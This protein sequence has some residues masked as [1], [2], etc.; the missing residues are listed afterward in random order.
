MKFIR[1]IILCALALQPI[2][3][4]AQSWQAHSALS[5]GTWH[6]IEVRETGVY[7]LGVNELAS[8]EG[9][10]FSQ[11]GLFGGNARQMDLD[12]T[13]PET[14]DLQP[15]AYRAVD[16]NNNGRLDAGDYL[17][18][19][20][21]GVTT[22]RYDPE[23]G[24]YLHQRHAYSNANYLFLR[25][26]CPSSQQ[27]PQADEQEANEAA[28]TEFTL[29]AVHE[30]ET[31]NT[32]NT[33]Q[34]W[35]GEKFLNGMSHDLSLPLPMAVSGSA[36]SLRVALAV[37]EGSGCF[38][39]SSGSQS[40]DFSL[41]YR[42]KH[43]VFPTT[44]SLSNSAQ[45]TFTLTYA[46][47]GTAAA[48]LDYIELSA[49]VP[50][51]FSQQTLLLHTNRTLGSGH[52]AQHRLTFS[53]EKPTVW[54]VTN[55]LSAIEM[56]TQSSGSTLQFTNPVDCR[57][58]YVVFAASQALTPV[59][60]TALS[61][62][63]L[64]GHAVPDMV[65]VSH[66]QFLGQAQRLGML[67]E[68]MEGLSV[69]VVTQDQVFNEFSSG[70]PDPVAVREMLRCLR[71]RDG[72]E[73]RLRYLLLFGKGTY[74]NRDILQLHLPT[75]ITYQS[76]RGFTDDCN[77]SVTD[78]VFG[79][80]DYQESGV[81]GRH[82]DLGIGRLPAKR[83][84][85]A[86]LMVDKIERYMNRADLEMS[87]VRGD[88]R[89]SVCLL[90]DDAD[91]SQEGDIDFVQSSEY[92]ANKIQEQAP[93]INL[94]KIYADAYLQQSGTIGSYYPDVNNALKQRMDY[95]CMLL[96]YI[97]HGS[98]Q[99]IGTERYIQFSDIDGY[100]NFDRLP[101]FVTSTCSYGK[102][103][104]LDDLCGSE[105]F[106]LARAAG[107]G[108]IAAARPI[109]HVKAFNTCLSAGCLDP[110]NRV[111]DA[112]RL[113]K[114]S[115]SQAQNNSIALM[116]DPALRLAFPEHRVVVTHINGNEVSDSRMD[117]ALVLSRVT[118]EGEIQDAQGQRVE[119]FDGIIY[120]VVYDR[121][122]ACRTL[123][124]DNEG[125]EVDFTQQKSIIYKGVE[126]VEGGR[127]SYSF[128]VPRDVPYQFD[129]CKLSHYAKSPATGS[130]ATG[131][132]SRLVLGGF[133]E[134]ADISESHPEI[135][136]YIGDTLFR[137]GGMADEE[138][139][140]LALLHDTIGINASGSG[141]GH[142]IVAILD[143]NANDPLI[144]NDLYQTDPQDPSRGQIRY[145]FT[146]LAPGRHTLSLK[147]W[148][149][150][151]YSSTAT[152]DFTVGASDVPQLSEMRVM[153]NPA[154]QRATLYVGHNMPGQVQEAHI[155][156]YDMLGGH[157]K[158]LPVELAE[159]SYAVGPAEWDLTSQTGT[160][161]SDGLYLARLLLTT[162]DGQ[163]MSVCAK[164]IV[165]K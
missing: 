139:T 116:G 115:Y 126:Q 105:A 73:S 91:P 61:H 27:I 158:S 140:L 34:I 98:E 121:P 25:T 111:G 95:G 8:L 48:Y 59:S 96:N 69:M 133:D 39:L 45:P 10:S 67:H 163:L 132:Y 125:T 19:Y 68:V 51:V 117:S 154:S 93:W 76:S 102:Y 156:I 55:P 47:S 122:T 38:T 128:V 108:C 152:I 120:P 148:N 20:A 129:R 155:E 58:D 15:Y 161:V 107:I 118:I 103:D 40:R 109:S 106:L 70:K 60:V 74:D 145:Q 71:S 13:T 57:R 52:Y 124:N 23:E 3:L 150:Y 144:L 100:Q 66:P 143:H 89:T 131:A 127:F 137:N 28:V 32:H 164:I 42:E 99:Y 130:D 29:C 17:L 112:L 5:E 162:T 62:Q 77:Y 49:S 160:T 135:R 84:D 64:H 6:R 24:A 75:V 134:N 92:L 4:A 43:Q 2:G 88:W 142:D 37:P 159:G 146:A 86:L 97:G 165:K 81:V 1:N 85:E 50:A 113:A 54:D 56:R 157:I 136:L 18:F 80:L 94:D 123:A 104:K 36:V 16:Q 63:D 53:G 33:S 153:P 7:R 138:A 41:S 26:D 11:I 82:L 30:Q 141:I 44:V 79:F 14:D 87:D 31:Y 151:N 46:S 147:A 149:I 72:E 110:A 119:T 78:D 21:E 101:F 9:R 35:V 12:N 22:W 90:A 114:N 83:D 65:I